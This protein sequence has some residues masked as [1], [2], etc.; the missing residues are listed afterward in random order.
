M[1]LAYGCIMLC[2][3]VS[4]DNRN[5]NHR[6]PNLPSLCNSLPQD[7][8]LSDPSQQRAFLLGMLQ[9]ELEVL[10]MEL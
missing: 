6:E 8:Q 9:V 1:Q 5:A 2:V 3:R 10:Q 4:D 7:P